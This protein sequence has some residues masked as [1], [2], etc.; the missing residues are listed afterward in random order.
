LRVRDVGSRGSSR[1]ILL[2]IIIQHVS[3][4]IFGVLQPLRHLRIIA[5]KCLIQRHRRSLA[6]LVDICYIFVFGVQ[7]DLSMILEVNLD[8]FVA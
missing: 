5:V 2:L 7:K 3:Q 8:D 6:L 4:N 1:R